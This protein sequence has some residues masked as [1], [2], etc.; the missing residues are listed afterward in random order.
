MEA[1][2]F[3]VRYAA[4][5]R[6]AGF[7]ERAGVECSLIPFRGGGSWGWAYS[8]SPPYLNGPLSMFFGI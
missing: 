8:S 2:Q 1:L 7:G 4:G 5:R 6:S 3:D